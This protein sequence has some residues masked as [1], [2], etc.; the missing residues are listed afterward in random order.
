M[1]AYI[2]KN[3]DYR[4]ESE[5]NQKGKKCPYCGEKTIIKELDAEELIKEN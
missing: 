4:F 3:C 5:N 1:T 2:C